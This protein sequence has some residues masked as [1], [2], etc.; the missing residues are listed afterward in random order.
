MDESEIFVQV[1]GYHLGSQIA[2]KKNVLN[3]PKSNGNYV[4]TGSISDS[5]D[6]RPLSKW[7]LL[8]GK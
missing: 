7:E 1:R 5:L 2:K 3:D 4:C 8:L 6:L